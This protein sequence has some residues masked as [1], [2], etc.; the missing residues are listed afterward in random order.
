MSGVRIGIH[1]R[2][3]TATIDPVDGF[4]YVNCESD[5]RVASISE[6]DLRASN[7]LCFCRSG[8]GGKEIIINPRVDEATDNQIN[9]DELPERFFVVV[10]NLPPFSICLRLIL[11]TVNR[12]SK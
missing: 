4:A 6:R 2:G 10:H 3:L 7:R 5:G 9:E 8:R 11:S 1:C 12:V